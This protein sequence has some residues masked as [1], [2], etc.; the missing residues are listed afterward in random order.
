MVLSLQTMMHSRPST[1]PMPVISPA[2]WIAS[3]YIPLAASGDSSRNGV[4]GSISCITRSR[5]SSLP[6]ADMALARARRPALRRLGAAA[7]QFIRE[8]AHL[9]GVGAELRRGRVDRGFERQAI[10]P[11]LHYTQS[12][13][14]E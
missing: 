14:R 6:R 4:P 1:R 7:H 12:R 10:P 9:R 11:A 3:S 8:R 5:G 13:G 2:P